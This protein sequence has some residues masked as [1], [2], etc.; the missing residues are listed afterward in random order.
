MSG[1]DEHEARD[2]LDA[3]LT[4]LARPAR[5]G[6][7]MRRAETVKAARDG[8]EAHNRR[9]HRQRRR[10]LKHAVPVIETAPRYG[11]YNRPAFSLIEL[12]LIRTDGA[13]WYTFAQLRALLPE[14]T[15]NGAK[16]IV[17]QKA[18]RLGLVERMAV[19]EDPESPWS[20]G[21]TPIERYRLANKPKYRYRIGAESGAERAR[22]R[23]KW[24]A[25]GEVAGDDENA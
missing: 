3:Y 16:A 4:K 1:D 11:R 8:I 5:G 2:R 6:K 21:E 15:T 22:M 14:T 9:H 18:R 17:F 13:K 23:E 20:A 12:L 25:Y 7:Q 10:K 19:V 24:R